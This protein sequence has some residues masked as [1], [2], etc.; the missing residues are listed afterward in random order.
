MTK[1]LR[2]DLKNFK[3]YTPSPTLWQISKESGVA[4]QKIMKLDTG[5]NPFLEDLQ[6]KDIVKKV[7]FYPYPDPFCLKLREKLSKYTGVD[8]DE[9]VC[10][11]GSDELID[12]IIRSFVE[13][14]EEIIINPPT[15]PMY[16][17]YAKLSG[18]KFITVLRKADLSVD[19]QKILKSITKKT[20]LVII[21][22]PGNP[23][24]NITEKKVFETILKKDVLVIAD[25][26]YFEYGKETVLELVKKYP[27]LIILRSL[28]KWAG[29]AGLRIGY[30]ISNPEIINALSS[31][32]PPYNI[33]SLTQ[34]FSCAFLD[35]AKQGLKRL[36]KLIQTRDEFIKKLSEF[37]EFKTYPS[38]GAYI[39]IKPNSTASDLKKYLAGKGVLIKLVDQP[40]LVNS[41]KISLPGQEQM[42]KILDLLKEFFRPKIDGLIFDM[43]GVLIDESKSYLL[44]IEKTVNYFLNE[45]KTN[46]NEV[47]E[48]KKIPGFNDDW[49][50]CYMILKLKKKNIPRKQYL[51]V[52]QLLS[53]R[54]RNSNEYRRI[55][56]IFQ[57][58]YL[59]S[60]DFEKNENRKAVFIN[61]SPLR[62]KEKLLIKKKLLN[63]LSKK[64]KLGI[65]T[66]RPRNEALFA[67]K[68][69]SLEDFFKK[70][71]LIAKED[72]KKVK[73]F[74]DPL[75]EAKRKM[76]VE[77]PVYIGDTVNDYLASQ[78]AK[79]NFIFVGVEKVGDI[80]IKNV[81]QIKEVI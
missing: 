12:L 79:M 9:I 28:S 66:G 59:G 78:R 47:L 21:D 24:G 18:V 37:K 71:L 15:F 62:L 32:K 7:D 6:N 33:N 34:E 1:Y 45:R 48:L 10:G 76:N 23:T 72:A 42:K 77:N 30:A 52:S 38:R 51:K 74:P 73:P 11:N 26:A 29:L 14:D 64:Y 67:L 13:R 36:D 20:K 46:K 31:L 56:D 53:D 22:S 35:N 65:A 60:K 17:F 19:L 75:L 44:A 2:K 50:S 40:G 27:N 43:D 61:N 68:Q 69:F 41:L 5:E 4:V 8:M 39:V 81:N 70:D 58:F 3:G 16:E 25:E 57:T 80:Q 63:T 55:K 54:E 49:D